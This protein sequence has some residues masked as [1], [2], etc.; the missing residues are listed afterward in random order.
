MDYKKI[1]EA[2]NLTSGRV[3]RCVYC[4]SSS[5]GKG[6]RYAPN[7]VHFHPDDPKKCSYCGSPNYGRGCKL[8]PMSDIHLH[9]I[10]FNS[11]L[12]ED[13]EGHIKSGF[14]THLLNKQITEFKAYKLGL[15]DKNGV[16]IKEPTTLTEKAA[17]TP[18]VKTILKI[19]R[20]LGPKLDLLN[21][22]TVLES[23]DKTLGDIK[24]YQK[25]L[26]FEEKI[27]SI[28]EELYKT[29]SEG[30]EEGLTVEQ[31]EAML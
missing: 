6:C 31:I 17:L 4:G 22:A 12:K 14:I 27:K 2:K 11:M 7:G 24:N 5:Y 3:N 9:G 1:E 20:F 10:N 30:L 21:G 8:N 13:L 16:K 19:R 23:I 25:T 18:E 28:Y 26:V 15:I 29:I